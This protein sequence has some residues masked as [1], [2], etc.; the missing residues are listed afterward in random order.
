MSSMQQGKHSISQGTEPSD[1]ILL[2]QSLAGDEYAFEAL[3][4]RYRSPLLEYMRR[5]LKDDEQA[6]DVLQFVLL[7]LY[8]SRPTLLRDVP[9]K[10]WL[11]QV[12]RHRCLDELRK[13]RRRPSIHFSE[14]S[15][16]DE[17]E[18]IALIE[19]ILDP[20]PVPEEI[21]EQLDLHAALHQAI[22]QLP[23][24]FRPIVHLRCFR[25]LTFSEIGRMLNMPETTVKTYFYRSL[26]RLRR[27]LMSSAHVAA[28]S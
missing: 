2:G 18:G 27:A 21:V 17:S 12:A 3:V 4:S 15:W 6:H 10:A 9:L 7:Q 8:V 25:Q 13:Q 28:V 14:L 24:R 1:G 16:E 20:R 26:P 23:L 19:S 5:V 22:R 11:F